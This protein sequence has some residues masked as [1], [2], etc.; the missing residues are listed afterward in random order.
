MSPRAPAFARAVLGWQ[1]ADTVKQ[2]H[3]DAAIATLDWSVTIRNVTAAAFASEAEAKNYRDLINRAASTRNPA[4]HLWRFDHENDL[5]VR[6]VDPNYPNDS[7]YAG[8]KSEAA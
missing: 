7:Q 4:A 5:C 8:L 1:M 2:S 6:Q 3:I